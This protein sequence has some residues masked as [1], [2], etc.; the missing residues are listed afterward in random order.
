MLPSPIPSLN[1]TEEETTWR[2][3]RKE[4]EIHLKKEET[5]RGG[6]GETV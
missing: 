5:E 6:E 4:V 2:G 3:E 1:G